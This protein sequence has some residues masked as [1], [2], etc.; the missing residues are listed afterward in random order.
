MLFLLYGQMG[1]PPWPLEIQYLGYKRSTETHGSTTAQKHSDCLKGYLHLN[2]NSNTQWCIK[3]K[4]S[5]NTA[6]QL[7]SVNDKVRLFLPLV[8]F[9]SMMDAK[10][11]INAMFRYL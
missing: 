7:L 1:H 8:V 2:I 3:P 10:L 6:S 4:N 11:K 9:S 5:V